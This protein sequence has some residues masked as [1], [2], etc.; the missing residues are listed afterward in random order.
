MKATVI[1]TFL[2]LTAVVGDAA[3]QYLG[4][5]Q[6]GMSGTGS[7]LNSHYVSP[8]MRSDGAVVGGHMRS[9]SNSTQLDNFGTRGNTNPYT[10]AVGTRGAVR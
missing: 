4:Q 3:A 2:L 8:H 5:G 10:G 6:G 9:N 1:V 7:N